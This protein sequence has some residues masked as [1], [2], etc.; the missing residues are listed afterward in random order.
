MKRIYL[1]LAII[2]I[3]LSSM[4]NNSIWMSDFYL[5]TAEAAQVPVM[6]T[7]VTPLS[8]VQCDV[9]MPA[10]CDETNTS[11]TLGELAEGGSI[12]VQ[13]QEVDIVR[14]IIAGKSTIQAGTGVI[15][16]LNIEAPCYLR[17][18]YHVDFTDIKFFDKN[19]AINTAGNTRC[20]INPP[21]L[22]RGDVTA[23]RIID[24]E[25]VGLMINYILN[26][27]NTID[28]VQGDL[29]YDGMIDVTDLNIAINAILGID[30]I[31]R[32][33]ATSLQELQ[34]VLNDAYTSRNYAFLELCTDNLV[35]NQ[36]PDRY[37]N[38]Y[39]L[40]AY[41]ANDSVLFCWGV[42]SQEANAYDTPEEM[43]KSCYDA[44]N[45]CNNVLK[46]ISTFDHVLDD[47]DDAVNEQLY[48]C[49]KGEALVSRAYHHWLL[50]NIFCM[51]WAGSEKSASL[52]GVPY[53]LEPGD[54]VNY[55][56]GRGTLLET[57][58]LIEQDLRDGIALLPHDADVYQRSIYHFTKKSAQAFAAKF[59]LAKRDY[60]KVQAYATLVFTGLMPDLNPVWRS[61]AWYISDIVLANCGP[62]N[63]AVLLSIPTYSTWSRRCIGGTRYGCK[64][65]ALRATIQGPGP[66]WINC[67]Y[68]ESSG[69]IF[70]MHPCF[71]S[72]LYANGYSQYGMLF[73]GNSGELFEYTD[74]LVGVG[75]VHMIRNEFT[76]EETLLARAEAR[77]FLGDYNGAL[78]DLS[79]WVE[80]RNDNLNQDNRVE[81][82][83]AELIESFYNG[84]PGFGIDKTLH[85]DEVCQSG[86][87]Q[88]TEEMLPWLQCVQHFLRIETIHTGKRWFDIKRYGLEIEHAV[89]S[90]NGTNVETLTLNDKRRAI[91]IPQA[92]ISAGMQ[93]NPR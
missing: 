41:S 19:G 78:A 58:N 4:A 68:R 17:S 11:F 82:L 88:V 63:P 5:H 92:A 67:R 69:E 64:D 84:T 74:K 35:D 53:M 36:A 81:T 25:D 13:R 77:I 79:A 47:P 59:Y 72:N 9:K 89:G 37:G 14:L 66:S 8:S 56:I 1:I 86:K 71:T 91:Q 57:Y 43:W 46:L 44:I 40:D 70:S 18:S 61:E 65:D 85:I 52:L 75:Y 29:N 33:Y 83:T 26:L 2:Y 50:A 51:P 27:D 73:G 24:I 23:D 10:W 16:Y 48:R 87:Y 34:Q 93:A 54:P 60:E 32:P 7:T 22:Q 90:V 6:L 49:I 21:A 76:N 39:W 12:T 3:A 30:T 20:I 38:Q 62:D 28:L 55:H 42:P 45:K 31:S 15:A 80:N